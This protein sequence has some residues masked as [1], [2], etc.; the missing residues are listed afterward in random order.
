[1]IG[2]IPRFTSPTALSHLFITIIGF[3]LGAGIG[4]LISAQLF[5]VVSRD[6]IKRQE[7]WLS[8]EESLL[9]LQAP[10]RSLSRAVRIL[11]DKLETEI[12][13]FALHTRREFPESPI[14][15]DLVALPLPQ[16]QSHASRLAR[17]LI[18]L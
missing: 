6:I 15:R 3:G 14:L 1:M 9:I 5:P 11:R 2:L 12:S 4:A 17:E 7:N 16:I 10:M 13:I 18:I 8:T